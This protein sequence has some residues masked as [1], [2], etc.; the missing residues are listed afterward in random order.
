MH[1]YGFRTEITLMWFSEKP[2]L[3]F[4]ASSTKAT[5]CMDFCCDK[6]RI[7]RHGNACFCL[8]P[9]AAQPHA[10]VGREWPFLLWHKSC[11]AWK[12]VL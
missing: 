11:C 7:Q 5:V 1:E 12:S 9:K 10:G 3:A 2:P 8:F 4:F 6:S